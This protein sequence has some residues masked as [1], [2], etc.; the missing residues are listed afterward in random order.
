MK[1]KL[2]ILFITTFSIF[3]NTQLTCITKKSN[4]LILNFENTGEPHIDYF[5]DLI[6]NSLFAF[7]KMIS[8]YSAVHPNTL[9]DYMKRNNYQKGDL[10]NQKTLF[11]ISK[12]FN[13][14]NIIRGKYYEKDEYIII[15]FE[16]IDTNEKKIIYRSSKFGK[17]GINIFET[18]DEIVISMVED[19]IGIKLEFAFLEI[20]TDHKCKLLIDDEIYGETPLKT[21]LLTGKHN[22]NIIYSDEKTEGS[23]LKEEINL[24]KD[25]VLNID[26]NVFVNLKIDAERECNV[27]LNNKKVGITPYEGKILSGNIYKLKVIYFDE[28]E[29]KEMLVNESDLSTID[30]KDINL[31]YPMYCKLNLESGTNPFFGSISENN[32]EELPFSYTNLFFGEYK[33]KIFLDDKKWNK[34]YYFYN[35]KIDLKP[36]EEKTIDLST[37]DYKRKFGFCFIPSAAQFYN[38]EYIKATLLL[39]FFM[40]TAT[41]AALSPLFSYIYYQYDYLPKVDE[42]KKNGSH[43]KYTEDDIRTSYYNSGYI[44]Q[45]FLIGGLVSSALIWIFSMID[46]II[47]MNHIYYLINP[48]KKPKRNKLPIAIR[49]VINIKVGMNNVK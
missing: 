23:I 24:T 9:K 49:P 26:I 39:S 45:G 42:W 17:G 8:D 18:L 31:F 36:L 46:G 38:R 29:K 30:R 16:V 12:D 27:L 5:D 41:I 10:E 43:G 35:K 33:V 34:R 13:A 28:E 20:N 11:K 1:N 25:Q 4:V 15:D 21:K 14:D 7:F 3:Y 19:F 22:I 48:D 44:F 47:N 6:Q 37:F 2:I 32:I 40:A